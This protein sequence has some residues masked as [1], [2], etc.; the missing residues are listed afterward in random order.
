MDQILHS[1]EIADEVPHW[2]QDIILI[3]LLLEQNETVQQYF[4]KRQQ[5]H[6]QWEHTLNTPMASVQVLDFTYREKKKEEE[7]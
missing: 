5:V 2:L 7:I 1:T 6:I 4:K 3:C